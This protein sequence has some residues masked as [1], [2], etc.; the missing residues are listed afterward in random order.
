[1]DAI[2]HA[3]S[4]NQRIVEL[5]RQPAERRDVPWVR[6]AAQ[7]AILLELATL[8]PYLCGKWS[9]DDSGDGQVFDTLRTII[10]DEMSHLGLA[11]NLLTTIGGTP[12]LADAALVPTYPGP[13]PGGVR[14]K[15]T[16]SLSG[17]TKESVTMYAEI[18]KPDDPVTERQETPHTSIGAFY[19][20]ILEALRASPELII[21]ARQIEMDMSSHGAGNSLV[22]LTSLAKVESAIEV[23]KEQGEGTSASPENPFPGTQGELAHYFAFLEIQHGRKLVH[24]PGY[25]NKWDF[26]G[27]EVPMPHA[28]PMGVVPAGGWPRT[29][30]SAP[31]PATV[32]LLDEFNRAFS[33]L[34]G[35]LQDAWKEDDGSQALDTLNEAVVAMFG[36]QIPAQDLM[37]IPLPDGS[38]KTYGP[39]FRFV[40]A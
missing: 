36:L 11:C 16:V 40:S 38:G 18:E 2:L 12:Q 15:L 13:L 26:Q 30:P 24:P 25:P 4:R 39:E 5:M 1:M 7:Q 27:P 8:P 28:L 19:T 31:A 32:Q 10:F 21:G 9:I 20:A 37:A 22:A 35:L 23:I 14:P 33:K 34:L 29:G 17:L 6:D 3:T